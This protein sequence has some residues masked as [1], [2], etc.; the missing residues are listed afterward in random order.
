M[1]NVEAI[2]I[3]I[4]EGITEFL[5]ISSTGHMVVASSIMGIHEAS[6][7]KLFEVVIQLGAIM[8]VVALYWKKFLNVNGYSFYLKLLIAVTPALFF[9]ALL[10]KHIDNALEIHYLLQSSCWW[11]EL[12]SCL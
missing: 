2:V 8:A 6:F 9:G 7:T 11:V 12:Y 5:P 3:A 10:K 4:I 1:T